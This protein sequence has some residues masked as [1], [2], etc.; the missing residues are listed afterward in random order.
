MKRF[1]SA[2]IPLSFAIVGIPALASAAEPVVD[3]TGTPVFSVITG[4]LATYNDQD[5]RAF[6]LAPSEHTANARGDVIVGF[7]A[8]A[9]AG[10]GL[11]PGI[12]R[13]RRTDGPAT[14]ELGG[15]QLNTTGSMSSFTYATLCPGDGYQV[16]VQANR[17]T[18]GKY[19]IAA[20]LIGD[21]N[22]DFEVGADDVAAIDAARGARPGEARYT[23]WVDADRNGVVTSTDVQLASSN[24]G[25]ATQLRLTP[26]NPLDQALPPN[27][28]AL[29]G[30]TPAGFNPRTA[31]LNFDLTGTQFH[32]EAT[33]AALKVNTT[34]IPASGLAVT[35]GRISTTGQVLADGRNDISFTGIDQAGRKVYHTSTV[36]AGSRNLLV[37]VVDEAGVPVSDPVTIRVSLTD[38]QDVYAETQTTAGQHTFGNVPSRT[39]LITAKASS[40]RFGTIGIFAGQGTVTVKLR[41]FGT[42]STVKNNDFSLGT[43]GWAVGG[44][45]VAIKPHVEGIPFAGLTAP[46]S[47]RTEGIAPLEGPGTDDPVVDKDLTLGTGG[48]GEQSVSRTFQ[49]DEDVT[50]LRIRYRFITTE[51]PGGY[52]GSQFNDYFRVSLRTQVGGGAS[53]EANS[54]NGLGLGAFDYGSGATQWQDVTLDVSNAGDT[55]QVDLG[56]AN[57]G[58]GFL[59]SYVVVD[60]VEEVRDRIRPT[61]TWNNTQGGLNLRYTVEGDEPLEQAGT[62]NVH[63]ANGAGYANRIGGAVFTHTVPAG[64]A[65]GAHGPVHIAGN[66]LAGDPAGT[67]HLIATSSPTRVGALADVVINFGAQANAGAVGAAMRD[68]VKDGLRAAGQANATITSTARSPEDQARAMFNNLVNPG[69][70]VAQN[71]QT[72][73]NMYAAAGDA[74]VNRFTAATAGMTLAQI[75]QNAATVQAAMVNEINAQGP[76]NVSRHCADPAVRNVVDVGMAA[77]NGNGGLFI[78]A[79]AGRLSHHIIE[80]NNNCYHLELAV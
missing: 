9:P 69:H 28:L 18:A 16:A 79:V 44:A 78:N 11:D 68:I 10:S 60:F 71:T 15:Q 7:S 38:D 63:F 48:Q 67:T 3:R 6:T 76:S 34:K 58:D 53:S 33:E 59:P 25:A 13:V 21:V 32:P 72:Q 41:G 46:A 49:L 52:Y 26:V 80:P 8:E 19:E 31:A 2:L 66:T 37:R 29:D 50:A 54:M 56:V 24:L 17:K 47:E 23:V 30:V 62:I 45:P 42:P 40:N 77:F 14:D 73:L 70:T 74:V 39:V 1:L 65:P 27:A 61:L 22:G 51:V 55:V 12:I 57:V 5:K 64:T 43:E 20:Y 35:P 75:N 36:W 4:E